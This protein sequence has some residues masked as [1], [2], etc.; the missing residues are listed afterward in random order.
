MELEAARPGGGLDALAFQ[1]AERARAR[2]LLESLGEAAAGIREG[3]EPELLDEE[4]SLRERL[5]E[6][7]LERSLLPAEADPE[8]ARAL[9]SEIAS[10]ATDYD[11][12]QSTIRT[13]SPRYSSLTQPRALTVAEI[14]RSVLGEG[15]RLL[16]YSLGTEKSFAWSV[17]RAD[18][19]VY[20]LPAAAAIE[21]L[22]GRA[23][24]ELT[25]PRGTG[26]D[27]VEELSKTLLGP[28]AGVTESER[29]LVVTEGALN[30]IPFAALHDGSG[31]PLVKS[32]E[33]VRLPSA[34]IVPVL[35][36]QR[37]GR[38][39][40]KWAAVAADPVY[41]RASGAPVALRRLASS[42]E[43]ALA[44][45]A[46][47]PPGAVDV[48]LGLAASRE[49]V[50]TTDF[51]DYRALHFATHG[52]VDD[53]EPA[54]SGVVLSLVDERGDARDGFLRLHDVYNLDLPVDLVVLSACE[55]GLGKDVRGEG[56]LGL[57]RGFL[58]AGAAAVVASAWNVDDEATSE[59]MEHFYRS[60]FAGSTPA[61]AL[62]RA[63]IALL[64]TR[65][66]AAPYYWAAFELQGDWR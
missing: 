8:T 63:Q 39:F 23:R 26:G 43:E 19:H 1:A 54:V 35:R 56:L 57:V 22:A 34:S 58:Y 13:R 66:F 45:Q 30:R 24:S 65:R 60:Y 17:T 27:A 61:A 59:L 9:S 62:R 10:L 29:L 7:A 2:T 37:A 25:S 51:R 3:I 47:A 4:R 44:I 42:R 12:L 40:T 49:W 28:V 6:A 15:T 53:R 21:E 52:I 41:G 48:V 64:E 14:Q 11:R 33:I 55:T 18:H 46:L 32:L 31:A 38:A 16:A 5:N 50:T 20:E 36:R